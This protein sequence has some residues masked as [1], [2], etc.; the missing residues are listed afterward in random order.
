MR[1]SDSNSQVSEYSLG[2]NRF[3]FY[4][5]DVDAVEAH[6]CVDIVA[7]F[8][9]ELYTTI[10]QSTAGC[11]DPR[12]FVNCLQV[13]TYTCKQL[14][15]TLRSKHLVYQLPTL[16]M[17]LCLRQCACTEPSPLDCVVAEMDMESLLIPLPM[18]TN[19]ILYLTPGVRPV[20][21]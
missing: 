15:K 19:V 10:N 8:T 9:E 4:C 7:K 12:V 13:Y 1:W 11:F 6:S 5:N 17:Y 14:T 2:N 18:A 3:L 21:S 16:L 20:M